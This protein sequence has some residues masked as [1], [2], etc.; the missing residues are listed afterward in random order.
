M[1][2]PHKGVRDGTLSVGIRLGHDRH[3]S[4][5]IQFI[6]DFPDPQD[7]GSQ[8]IV[9]GDDR[10]ICFFSKARIHAL[11]AKTLHP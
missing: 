1:S 9:H 2:H 3:F 8:R 5:Q 7:H 11:S 4:E 10:Q 6:E